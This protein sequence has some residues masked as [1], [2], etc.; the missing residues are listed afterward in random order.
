MP[1]WPHAD[2]VPLGSHAIQTLWISST[3]VFQPG[4]LPALSGPVA[5]SSGSHHTYLL[6]CLSCLPQGHTDVEF[7]QFKLS[8]VEIRYNPSFFVFSS[9]SLV[10]KFLLRVSNLSMVTQ[11]L[12]HSAL[13][14]NPPTSSA[15]KCCL[16]SPKLTVPSLALYPGSLFLPYKKILRS[17]S[18][19]WVCKSSSRI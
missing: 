15:Q 1:L 6:C 19:A 16:P 3:S 17:L 11:M 5:G 14:S 7:S 10:S 9:T 2:L 18:F 12:T 4:G 8:Q 13:C